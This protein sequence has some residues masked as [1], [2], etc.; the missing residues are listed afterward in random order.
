MHAGQC[1]E[2]AE[3]KTIIIGSASIER[4]VVAGAVAQIQKSGKFSNDYNANIVAFTSNFRCLSCP[5]VAVF[6]QCVDQ[7]SSWMCSNRLQL[8]ADKTEVMWCASACR[9]SQFPRCPILVAGASIEPVNAVRE[10]GVFIDRDLDPAT[11][12]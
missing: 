8:K 9:Q 6:T 10:L 2:V 12:L 7:I 11:H 1:I 5:P 3:N 4:K